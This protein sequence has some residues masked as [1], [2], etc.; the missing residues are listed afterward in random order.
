MIPIPLQN[1]PIIQNSTIVHL[2]QQI[3]RIFQHRCSNHR[4]ARTNRVVPVPKNLNMKNRKRVQSGVAAAIHAVRPLIIRG[5]AVVQKVEISSGWAIAER[6]PIHAEI[7]TRYQ[8]PGHVS[9]GR[10]VPRQ[11]ERRVPVKDIPDDETVAMDVD[12]WLAVVAGDFE[13]GGA[14]VGLLW[15]W[16]PKGGFY[17]QF[18]ACFGGA[19]CMY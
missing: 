8:T 3:D 10:L 4:G 15:N 7:T 13:G 6:R 11:Q 17:V 5:R 18:V 2:Q 9:T 1:K 14:T 12:E 16:D 19:R